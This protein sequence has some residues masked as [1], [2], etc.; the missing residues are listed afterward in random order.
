MQSNLKPVDNKVKVE[1][2][3]KLKRHTY[4]TGSKIFFCALP[5]CTKKLKIGLA[6][7]K[8]SI[9]WRCGE[10]FIMNEYSIRLAKPH[11]EDC[12]KS[13][14]EPQHIELVKDFVGDIRLGQD[15]NQNP[16]II[17]NEPTI[18]LSQRLRQA[19]SIREEDEEI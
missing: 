5:K 12:H 15:E 16:T 17:L 7:G 1:H 19:T 9:C 18:P 8:E 4:E 14:D 11:C 13:K 6:L 3:C 2:I 10:P